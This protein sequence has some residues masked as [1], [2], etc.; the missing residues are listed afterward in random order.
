MKKILFST[1]TTINLA[2]TG[3]IPSTQN[4]ND[5]VSSDLP[6][7]EDHQNI[8]LTVDQNQPADD[9][10]GVSEKPSTVVK[11]SKLPQTDDSISSAAQNI[12]VKSEKSACVIKECPKGYTQYHIQDCG[13]GP[14]GPVPC[15]PEVK[16][17]EDCECHKNCWKGDRDCPTDMP[18]CKSV[19][20]SDFSENLCFKQ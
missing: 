19:I 1:L 6:M 5:Q 17:Q 11:K 9:V 20:L 15:P 2:F 4:P 8:Q 13:L 10:G 12:A 16:Q 3:C 18:I 14:D 7:I